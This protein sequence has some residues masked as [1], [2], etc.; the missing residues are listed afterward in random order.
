MV[1]ET[2]VRAHVQAA[3]VGAIRKQI[4][5]RADAGQHGIQDRHACNLVFIGVVIAVLI[6]RRRDRLSEVMDKRGKH[7]V[8]RLLCRIL[9]LR[10][11][12]QH[13]H[14]MHIGHRLRDGISD[15]AA[16]R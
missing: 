4:L 3:H 11:R 16:R 1:I 13:E 15:F 5:S 14:R 10:R 9:H 2:G 8:K 12:T 6:L 7:Q